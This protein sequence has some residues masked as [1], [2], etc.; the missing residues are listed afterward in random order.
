MPRGHS[1][2][3]I[4]PMPVAALPEM[5]DTQIDLGRKWPPGGPFLTKVYF[6]TR[7]SPQNGP[8]SRRRPPHYQGKSAWTVAEI[9]TGDRSVKRLSPLGPSLKILPPPPL[10]ERP[11][12]PSAQ[13]PAHR[14]RGFQQTSK[15][16]PRTRLPLAANSDQGPRHY[17]TFD[18]K[19]TSQ[20]RTKP[21]FKEKVPISARHPTITAGRRAPRTGRLCQGPAG[22]DRGR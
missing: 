2:K 11:T 18:T 12:A 10:N 20:P 5:P 17:S 19:P 16:H 21:H 6:I 4:Q 1:A 8:P 14:P 9:I 7:H 13:P 22:P 15:P 3:G